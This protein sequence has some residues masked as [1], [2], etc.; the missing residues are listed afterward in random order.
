MALHT[1]YHGDRLAGNLGIGIAHSISGHIF[2]KSASIAGDE[3]ACLFILN[4]DP[5]DYEKHKRPHLANEEYT[6]QESFGSTTD[7]LVEMC[8]DSDSVCRVCIGFSRDLAVFSLASKCWDGKRYIKWRFSL[9]D[10]ADAM[11]KRC[12]FCGLIAVS[13]FSNVVKD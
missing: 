6:Y 9:S 13:L 1:L 2:S 4:E 12:Q 10:L 3:E 8:G 7:A 11:E 5:S